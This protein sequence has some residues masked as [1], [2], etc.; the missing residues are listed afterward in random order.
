MKLGK[1]VNFYQEGGQVAA[2]DPMAQL[3]QGAADALQAND[4]EMMAQVCMQLLEMAG[5]A[6]AP[7]SEPA[8]P[9][10]APET[11]EPV[12]KMGGRLLR[13]VSRN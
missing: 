8:A 2:A 12:Y 6:P 1:K 3:L 10:A 5:A 9:E 13:R 4:C 11:G 7:A